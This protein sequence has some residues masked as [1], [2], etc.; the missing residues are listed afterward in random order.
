MARRG[1][2]EVNPTAGSLL[3]FLTYGTMTGWDLDGLVELSIGNFW[4]V[5]RSQIYRELRDLAGRGLVEVGDPGPRDR[6]PYTITDAGREAFGGWIASDPGADLTRSR[7]LLTVFFGDKLPPGRLTEIL[8]DAR[9]AHATRLKVYEGLLPHVETSSAY[10]AATL[11]FG[12]AYQ[13]A[14]LDWIDGVASAL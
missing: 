6:T 13:R 3:G 10:Q 14:M 9:R 12:I 5:T 4:N 1:N 7:L 8:D 11:K 2:H